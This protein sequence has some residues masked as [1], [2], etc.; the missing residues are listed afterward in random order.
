MNQMEN[1]KLYVE[2]LLPQGGWGDLHLAFE[3]LKEKLQREG[4]FGPQRIKISL[5]YLPTRNR[6]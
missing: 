4:L 5:P 6:E 2:L 1:I 3:Q